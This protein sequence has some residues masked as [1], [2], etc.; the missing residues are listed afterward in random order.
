MGIDCKG[1]VFLRGGQGP[2][3]TAHLKIKPP[4]GPAR[5][6]ILFTVQPITFQVGDTLIC[7]IGVVEIRASAAERVNGKELFFHGELHASPGAGQRH[8]FTAD[9]TTCDVLAAEERRRSPPRAA[10]WLP[11]DIDMT[12]FGRGGTGAPVSPQYS[13]R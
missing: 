1:Y 11:D 12:P 2:G 6:M 7:N 3:R 8:Q 4:H 9:A 13:S 10:V 5:T